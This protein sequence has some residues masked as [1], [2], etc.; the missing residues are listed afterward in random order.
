MPYKYK[1]ENDLVFG[2]FDLGLVDIRLHGRVKNQQKSKYG[3]SVFLDID[4]YQ[5]GKILF[6]T[7][8]TNVRYKLTYLNIT[9]QFTVGRRGIN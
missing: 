9:T 3:R 8:D 1:S 7:C 4:D 6:E 5:Q 2:G